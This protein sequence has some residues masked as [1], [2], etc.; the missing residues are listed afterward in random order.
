[1]SMNLLEKTELWINHITLNDVNL[2]ELAD[3]VAGVLGLQKGEVMV[4]D[5]RPQHITFDVLVQE[6]P[7]ENFLGKEKAILNALQEI[8]GVTLY[9]DTYIHSNGILGQICA[10]LSDE[11]CVKSLVHEKCPK[12]RSRE[13]TLI[14]QR[15]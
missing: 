1:M 2:T 9:E 13:P 12:L 15:L 14:L 7:Q 11:G 5:V 6:I 4:V 10:N 3:T 8:Q